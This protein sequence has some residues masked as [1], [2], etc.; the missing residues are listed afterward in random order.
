MRRLLTIAEKIYRSQSSSRHAGIVWNELPARV[1]GCF[2][3][4]NNLDSEYFVDHHCKA[5]DLLA[6][7]GSM[8]SDALKNWVRVAWSI[9]PRAFKLAVNALDE[10]L[11]SA[12]K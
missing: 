7:P 5:N 6:V 3:L 12:L 11:S 10:S 1:F 2:E 4:P 9:E 8:F